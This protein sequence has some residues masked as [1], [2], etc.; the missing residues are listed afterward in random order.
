[1]FLSGFFFPLEAM[2]YS[3]QALSHVVPLRYYLIIIRGIV[4]KGIGLSILWPEVATV[5]VMTCF[6]V[7][8]ASR[9]FRETLD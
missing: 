9:R 2:P 7:V 3:L 8:L 5:G 1:M 4:L 6:L